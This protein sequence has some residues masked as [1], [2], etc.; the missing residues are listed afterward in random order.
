MNL[1]SPQ[2]CFHHT[3]FQ[4]KALECLCVKEM[5]RRKEME[6][7]L[8]REKQEVQKMKDQCDEFIKELQM[9]KDQRAVLES[10][11]AESQCTVEELEEKIISAVELL[12][13][14]KKKRDDMQIEHGN[15][16][17]VLK[18]LRKL[19][20][21]EDVS[22][23][24]TEI[25]EFSFMEINNATRNFDPSWKIG[26][27]KYGSVYKGLLRHVHVAIKMLPSYGSQS[28]LEFENEV[29]FIQ[30]SPHLYSIISFQLESI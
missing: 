17:R 9:V 25:L 19:V 27:G 24:G 22:F 10:Q 2:L 14:F 11:I 30:K 15:A 1:F 26:E 3:S 16:I 13:S 5:S 23:P 28:L 8:E 12:I 21:G 20:N 4:E 7:F 6:E 29:N 18:D